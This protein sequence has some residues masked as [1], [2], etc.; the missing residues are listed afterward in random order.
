[1]LNYWRQNGVGGRDKITAYVSVNPSNIAHV[2]A[3]I[4][5]FG[6]VYTGISLP[7]T[8]QTQH[9]WDVVGDGRTGNSAPGSWGGHAVPYLVY[10]PTTFGVV[11]WGDVLSLT[12]RF[13]EAYTDEL[14]AVISPQ[15]LKAGE[16]PAGFNLAALQSDLAAL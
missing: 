1:V 5:L 14:Y 9:E 2:K 7:L 15:F 4:Y 10:T 6:G 16:S 11:T 3:A 12:T 13:H 8:A